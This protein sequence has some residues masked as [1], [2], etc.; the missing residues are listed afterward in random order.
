MKGIAF[1]AACVLAGGCGPKAVITAGPTRALP[2][3][4]EIV[5]DS[6]PKAP[7]RMVPPEV[8]LRAYLTWFGGLSP[9]ATLLRAREGD[10][11]DQWTDYLAALGLPDHHFDVP[12]AMQSNTVMLAAIGRLGEA[13]CIRSVELELRANTPIASRVIFA[14]EA[15]P[16]PTR[17]QFAAGFDVLHRTFLGYPAGL[18]PPQRLERFFELHQKVVA[19]HAAGQRLTPDE[20]AWAAVCTALVQHPETG[21]Y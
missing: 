7:R 5:L 20:M 19:N 12:R 10:L 2:P 14:F 18:G 6:G 15:T 4:R 11:F 16:Q 9:G 3:H 13:L 17:A 1:V 8:F 21:L